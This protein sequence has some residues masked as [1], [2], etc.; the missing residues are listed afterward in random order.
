MATSLFWA[1]PDNATST[2]FKTWGTALSAALTAVG[3]TKTSDSGQVSWSGTITAPSANA[4]PYY[5]IWQLTDTLAATYPYLL[6]VEYGAGNTASWPALRITVGTGSNGSGTLTGNVSSAMAH[7]AGN[8]DT[9]RL[10][11]VFVSGDGSRLQIALWADGQTPFG[12]AFSISRTVNSAGVTNGNGINF[13]A[14][15][16]YYSS[17][18]QAEFLQQYIPPSGMGVPYPYA[19][20]TTLTTA[21]PNSGY[22]SLGSNLGVFP[23]FPWVGYADNPDMGAIAY[24]HN[25]IPASGVT[26]TISMYGTNHNYVTVSNGQANPTLNGNTNGSNLMV[27]YE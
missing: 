21:T 17:G 24:F 9:T 18:N 7:S 19:V 8:T 1:Y 14:Y 22:G 20:S 12:G 27:R 11:P 25:D 2:N 5:E 3:L 15:T 16:G 26:L 6:K 23:V 13:V 10:H 4:F